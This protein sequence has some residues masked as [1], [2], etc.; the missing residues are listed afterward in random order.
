VRLVE[1]AELDMD[2]GGVRLETERRSILLSGVVQP[3]VRFHCLAQGGE[4]PRAILGRIEKRASKTVDGVRVILQIC[5]RAAEHL[6]E[7]RVGGVEFDR[8]FQPGQRRQRLVVLEKR[9]PKVRMGRG[10]CRVEPEGFQI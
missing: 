10:Q 2:A 4:Q 1:A 3:A 7:G 9:L 5:V 8:L 6:V